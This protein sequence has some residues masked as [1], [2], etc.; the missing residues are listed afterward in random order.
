[1]QAV[2]ELAL[3]GCGH[4]YDILQSVV[5]EHTVRTLATRSEWEATHL[6]GHVAAS[7]GKTGAALG[8]GGEHG[9][10]EAEAAAEAA[11]AAA[12]ADVL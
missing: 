12:A 6:A 1:M 10:A 8:A 3:E 7:T 9:E 4:V 5:R 11:A 2:F